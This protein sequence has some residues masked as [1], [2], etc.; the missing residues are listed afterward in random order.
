M[1]EAHGHTERM[2]YARFAFMSDPDTEIR[3]AEGID[4][5]AFMLEKDLY[6]RFE[7]EVSEEVFR[8][9]KTAR[10]I[11]LDDLPSLTYIDEGDTVALSCGGQTAEYTVKDVDR[12]KDFTEE[13][14]FELE[15]DMH[16][17]ND[18]ERMARAEEK[19]NSAKI[20]MIIKL[21]RMRT[22]K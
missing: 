16:M 12:K 1:A 9:A 13:E 5:A 10:E 20:I 2:A 3:P 21:K 17:Y 4:K 19:F 7:L 14:A 22:G 11:K 8:A 15:V 18:R 6:E